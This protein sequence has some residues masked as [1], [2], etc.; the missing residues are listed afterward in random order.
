MILFPATEAAK[1]FET[2]TLP[3][4]AASSGP[5]AKPARSGAGSVF[6]GLALCAALAS[7]SLAQEAE[8]IATAS[9]P[10]TLAQTEDYEVEIRVGDQVFAHPE[11]SF[12]VVYEQLGDLFLI[13]LASGGNACPGFFLWLDT[14]EGN[15]QETEPFGTCSDLYELSY[16]EAEI[17]LKVPSLVTGQGDHLYT[18]DGAGPV[19]E[20]VL[21]LAASDTPPGADPRGWLG[22]HPA[23]LLGSA[24]WSALLLNVLTEDELEALRYAMKL[25]EGFV[26]EDGWI[27]GY[28]Y[29]NISEDV[30]AIAIHPEGEL[31]VALG[32]VGEPGQLWGVTERA[33]PKAIETVLSGY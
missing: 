23:E 14:T 22:R 9:G 13:F 26:E 8:P 31:L 25:S 11:A 29:Q 32:A 15:L 5:A 30:A 12:A 16:T 18:W 3:M 10:L 2:N 28:G 21:E 4:N 7:P 19:V 24:D 17:S 6:A 27:V 33:Y 1:L 20:T